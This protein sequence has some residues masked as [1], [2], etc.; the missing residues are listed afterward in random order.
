[1]FLDKLLQ[2][3]VE[4]NKR[5]WH[6]FVGWHPQWTFQKCA[7][8]TRQLIFTTPC[9]WSAVDATRVTNAKKTATHLLMRTVKSLCLA[10]SKQT[11][12]AGRQSHRL[13]RPCAAVAPRDTRH[14]NDRCVD[15][16]FRMPDFNISFITYNIRVHVYVRGVSIQIDA[17]TADSVQAAMRKMRVW[18]INERTTFFATAIIVQ[19]CN[20]RVIFLFLYCVVFVLKFWEA[21][22]CDARPDRLFAMYWGEQTLVY[23][24]MFIFRTQH[25]SITNPCSLWT[26]RRV[27]HR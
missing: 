26:L 6:L 22:V 9:S 19:T 24:T 13:V 14:T 8:T 18:E 5:Y 17:D 15:A 11:M 27:R 12:D 3:K 10:L 4:D 21:N 1:M 20:E 23:S 7:P 2:Q 25:V 16:K